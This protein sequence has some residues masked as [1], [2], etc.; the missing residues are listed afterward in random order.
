MSTLSCMAENS[1]RRRV[2]DGTDGKYRAVVDILLSTSSLQHDIAVR[3]H[4]MH[5]NI[6][7]DCPRHILSPHESVCV[8]P[9]PFEKVLR[10][11]IIPRSSTEDSD[12]RLAVADT[13][14]RI[15]KSGLGRVNRRL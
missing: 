7:G 8:K 2:I 1:T 14:R 6:N 15:R 13:T 11:W 9:V 5:A 4:Q 12:Q 3:L 10:R